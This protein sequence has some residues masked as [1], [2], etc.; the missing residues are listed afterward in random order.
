MYQRRRAAPLKIWNNLIRKLESSHV[1]LPGSWPNDSWVGLG[2]S[3]GNAHRG[4]IFG[5][6]ERMK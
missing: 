5:P 6:D 1:Q 4:T 2:T 3:D